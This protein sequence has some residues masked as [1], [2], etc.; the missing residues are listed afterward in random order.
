M[1]LTVNLY[2]VPL[3]DV[4]ILDTEINLHITQILSW[5]LKEGGILLYKNLSLHVS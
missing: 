1:V 5:H 2:R 4:S 3:P